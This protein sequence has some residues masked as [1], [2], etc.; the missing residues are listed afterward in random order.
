VIGALVAIIH[1]VLTNRRRKDK[2]SLLAFE[3]ASDDLKIYRT[4]SEMQRKESFLRELPYTVLAA[5]AAVVTAL[6]FL[7][8]EEMQRLMVLTDEL[9]FLTFLIFLSEIVLIIIAVTR[10]KKFREE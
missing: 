10:R 5:T 4:D 9:T 2:Y 7:V 6:L 8:F 3:A 1:C